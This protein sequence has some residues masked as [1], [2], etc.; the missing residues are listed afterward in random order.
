MMTEKKMTCRQQGTYDAHGVAAK[1]ME[2]SL[3]R[4]FIKYDTV[5]SH[6]LYKLMQILQVVTLV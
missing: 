6:N 5:E 2:I 4:R 1:R 3:A